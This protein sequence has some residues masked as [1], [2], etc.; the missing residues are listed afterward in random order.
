MPVAIIEISKVAGTSTTA[1]IAGNGAA[2]SRKIAEI[3]TQSGLKSPKSGGLKLARY[4]S[5]PS[6]A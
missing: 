3:P 6:R 4:V 5:S 1:F 2:A